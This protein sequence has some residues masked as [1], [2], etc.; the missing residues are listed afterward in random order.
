[1]CAT[2]KIQAVEASTFWVFVG[3][4]KGN[5][6]LKIFH[7]ILKYNDFFVAQNLSDKCF[8]FH[9]DLPLKGRTWI[10]KIPREKPWV[11]PEVKLLINP[12][13]TQ[14]T[15]SQE[16]NR[17]AMWDTTGTKNYKTLRLP[18]IAVVP[19]A[20]VEW[21]SKK[22]HTANELSIWLEKMIRTEFS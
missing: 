3:M 19:Y 6:K 17:H 12:I 20:V 22:G 4:V 8:C 2:F 18:R 21:L 11:W 13:E 7:S 10:F 14:T 16:E 1:M 9:G 15:F 5:T